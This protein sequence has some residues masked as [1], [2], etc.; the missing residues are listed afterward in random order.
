MATLPDTASKTPDVP[1]MQGNTLLISAAAPR[2][3]QLLNALSAVIHRLPP[4]IPGIQITLPLTES[5]LY[6]GATSILLKI[7]I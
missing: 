4:R 2:T 1:T 7:T 5:A 3:D 6:R